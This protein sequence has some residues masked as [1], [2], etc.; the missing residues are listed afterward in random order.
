MYYFFF[1]LPLNMSYTL[2]SSWP[3]FGLQF[4]LYRYNIKIRNY[5]ALGKSEG[6]VSTTF[7]KCNSV[8][9]LPGFIT[10]TYLYAI[11][12]NLL[13]DFCGREGRGFSQFF[14]PCLLLLAILRYLLQYSTFKFR[15]HYLKLFL[16]LILKFV[17]IS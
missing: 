9:T 6:F 16:L 12:S 8:F 17:V 10:H 11:L 5:C 14:F 15:L 7:I 1:P 4:T 13:A 3:I 2:L